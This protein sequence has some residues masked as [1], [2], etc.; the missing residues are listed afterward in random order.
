MSAFGILA[1]ACGWAHEISDTEM[2]KPKINRFKTSPSEY[3]NGFHYGGLSTYY[4]DI[5]LLI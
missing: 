3:G 5:V 4:E 1:T 2:A